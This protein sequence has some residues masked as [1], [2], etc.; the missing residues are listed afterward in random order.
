M[1]NKAVTAGAVVLAGAAIVW[2][3][4]RGRTADKPAAPNAIERKE[5]VLTVYKDDFGMVR[6]LRPVALVKGNNPIRVQDVSRLLDP[7][8]VL[9]GWQDKNTAAQ[10]TAHAYDLGVANGDG[11]LKRYL[12]KEVEIVR[13]G[14]DGREAER[15]KGT[16]MVN[17]G[18]QVVLESDGKFIVNPQGTIVAASTPDIIPIPQLSVQADSPDATN[19]A[20]DVAYLTRGLSWSADYVAT[21]APDADTLNLGCWATVTNRTGADYP[22]AK[23]TLVA[24]SPNR[25]TVPGEA[26]KDPMYYA[27]ARPEYQAKSRDSVGH[28]K[29]MVGNAQNTGEFHE[30]P[31]KSATTV[32]Q[33][34]MNRLL[35]LS[36]ANVSVVRDY[37]TRPANLSGYDEWDGGWSSGSS[38]PERGSV[39]VALTFHNREK[40]GLGQPLP[41]G[42]IRL[43]EP[44]ASGTLRYAGAANITDT[45]RD[46]SVY[47]TLATA[48]DVFTEGRI[49]KK[50]RVGK[51][52]LRKQIELSLYNEKQ[53]DVDLRIVQGFYGRWKIVSESGKHT[54]LDSDTAQWK[55]HLA[56]HST[57]PLRFTVEFAI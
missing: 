38:N 2:G 33:E 51:H 31:V 40:D 47:L 52:T 29:Q 48:F 55:I 46:Q 16:L 25:A 50:Q 15:T 30:Y 49:V 14:M 32:V 3:A 37:N 17:S 44:D 7:Q 53:K 11:L 26:R 42:A 23:V 22:N 13:Y 56:A 12:G 20:L 41:S 24:G 54:N 34:Q 19:A 45:P 5:V 36:S 21:L 27:V 4:N 28:S 1:N 18:N 35:M 9:L 43:Y 57:T 39:A 10:I 6:E 8:S